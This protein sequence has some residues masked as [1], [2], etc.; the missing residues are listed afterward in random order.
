M[1]DFGDLGVGKINHNFDK[2]KHLYA[3]NVKRE[4]EHPLLVE[5]QKHTNAVCTLS[6]LVVTV[7][8]GYWEPKI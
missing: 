8:S 7:T 2:Y 5:I 6:S 3:H 1:S 4:T